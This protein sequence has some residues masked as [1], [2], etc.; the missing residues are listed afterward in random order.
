[1]ETHMKLVHESMTD[2]MVCYTCV[3]CDFVTDKFYKLKQHK[4]LHKTDIPL[5]PRANNPEGE[6]ETVDI[7]EA[8]EAAKSVEDFIQAPNDLKSF[9]LDTIN[10]SKAIN[11]TINNSNM[12]VSNGEQHS[13]VADS[14]NKFESYNPV[15]STN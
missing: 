9:R 11:N 7:F 15:E 10:N 14:Y 2:G 6:M 3:Q 5:Y 4:F 13:M 12:E 1:M 8:L